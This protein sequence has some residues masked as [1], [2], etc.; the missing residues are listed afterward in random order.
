MQA[1]GLAT[2]PDCRVDEDLAE[3]RR[4]IVL[5]SG[6][7]VGLRVGVWSGYQRTSSSQVR[8]S[9]Y[10]WRRD[11][12]ER[13]NQPPKGRLTRR[14]CKKL[15]LQRHHEDA[16]AGLTGKWVQA[17]GLATKPRSQGG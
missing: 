9:T 6:G 12:N 7:R 5:G 15:W 4:R 13:R 3:L 2:K 17:A 14:G 11:G 10:S 1:A 8:R 16:R